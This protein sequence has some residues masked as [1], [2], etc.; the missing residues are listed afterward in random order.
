MKK[1]WKIV[2][3][4]FAVVCALQFVA[5]LVMS[6]QLVKFGLQPERGVRNKDL[7]PELDW[8]ENIFHTTDWFNELVDAGLM[9]DTCIL[10]FKGENKLQGYYCPAAEPSKRTA[11]IAHGYTSSALG[12]THIARMFRDSLGFNVVLPTH[13]A[14]FGSEGD[15][16]QMGWFDRLNFEKWSALG[17]KIFGDTLQV[18]HGISMGGATVMMASGDDLPPYVRGI[19]ED[20]G[21]TS[22][23]D[24]FLLSVKG[25]HLSPVILA[26]GGL[27][28]RVRWGWGFKE[29]S[30]L[31]Q[32]EKSTVPMLFIH[33]DSD[34]FVPTEMVYRCYDA[35]KNGYKEMWLGPGSKHGA[36]FTDHPA[37]YTAVVRKFLEQHVF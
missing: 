10:D 15:A 24:Q 1:R 4:V 5:C 20:C 33:G 3:I 29:A 32:L 26:M 12:M 25:M 21:Y 28:T 8:M 22:V 11:I 13:Y 14:H 37:E 17:H 19:I 30:S 2:L 9:R 31:K 18:Y 6:E 36:S 27:M 35:K 34:D 7:A 16:V 23:W